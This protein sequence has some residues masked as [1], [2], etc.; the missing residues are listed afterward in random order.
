MEVNWFRVIIGRLFWLLLACLLAGLALG[1]PAWAL[2]IGLSGYLGWTLY[3]MQRFQHWLH[4]RPGDPPPETTGMWGEIF[5]GIYHMQRRDKRA[6]ARLQSVIE[7][8]QTSTAALSDA[9]VVLDKDGHLEWW[10]HSAER[11][12]GLRAPDDSGQHV[13]NLLRDPRFVEYFDRGSYREPLDIPSPLNI[14]TW[15]QYNITRYGN[16][17]RLMLVRDVTRLHNL[18]QMRKDFVANVSHELRTP[19]TVVVGYLETMIDSDD[20]SNPRWLRPLHQMQQQARRMQSLLNDLLML[21][22]LETSEARAEEKPVN[23][24]LM[25]PGIRKDALA[26]SGERQHNITLE[27]TTQA[28]IMGLETEL[29]SAISNLVYNAVKYTQD[30]GQIHISWSQDDRGARLS[31]SDNGPGIAQEHLHRLTERFY[32]VDSSRNSTTGGTGLGLAIV[33]HVLMRHQGE[34]QITSTLGQGSTFSCVFP[35]ER[36]I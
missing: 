7:R 24:D 26:L 9:V 18:E 20:G 30:G 12:L 11:L 14:S 3:Q 5:D 2:V 17:E 23:I 25:L 8:I 4:N 15:L 28:R 35:A 6:R 33:K 13:H 36:L 10:N 31:V 21:S 27:C 16:G 34:L 19:L 29:R 22:R 1:Q 32:R